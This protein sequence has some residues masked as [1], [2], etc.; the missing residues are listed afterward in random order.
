[1][2]S[3][4][5]GPKRTEI[6]TSFVSLKRFSASMALLE[7]LKSCEKSLNESATSRSTI[8]S[9][10]T[11]TLFVCNRPS[12][13]N[14]SD[15]SEAVRSL[16]VKITQLSVRSKLIGQP[17]DSYRDFDLT[18]LDIFHHLVGHYRR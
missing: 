8:H 16:L 11:T 1:M 5:E 3:L 7:I 13:F 6:V 2:P 15:L 9:A 10:M 4:S 14:A 18:G 12:R 17:F